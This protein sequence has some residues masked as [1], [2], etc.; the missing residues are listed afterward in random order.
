MVS[1]HRDSCENGP[2]E[3]L[4]WP[5]AAL[6]CSFYSF[7]YHFFP[8]TSFFSVRM[9]N[10]SIHYNMFHFLIGVHLLLS[11]LLSLSPRSTIYLFLHP[12][13]I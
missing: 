13:C 7:Q 5:H 4:W 3:P 1:K 2:T 6:C 11:L 12:L 9:L 8:K 10:W